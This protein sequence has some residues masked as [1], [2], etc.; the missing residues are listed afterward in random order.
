MKIKSKTLKRMYKKGKKKYNKKTRKINKRYKK[1]GAEETCSMCRK[2]VTNGDKFVPSSCLIK[3]GK[4]RSHKICSDC[5]WNKFAQEG[6]NH[7]CPG[8]LSGL[9]LNNP[10]ISKI[11]VIDLTED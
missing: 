7:Q 9:P 5:W 11:E 4:F 6:V 1:G 8:C 10:V 3:H 2:I